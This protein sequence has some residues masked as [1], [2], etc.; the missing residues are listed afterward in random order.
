AFGP[1]SKF[2]RHDVAEAKKLITAAGR[3]GVETTLHYPGSTN[4]APTD[5]APIVSIYVDNLKDG[6]INAKQIEDSYFD[7]FLPDILYAYVKGGGGGGGRGFNG[8]GF[9][10]LVTSPTVPLAMYIHFHKDGS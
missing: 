7:H 8:L 9:Q 3:N 1:N 2:Y 6:G 10:T 5:H 4:S